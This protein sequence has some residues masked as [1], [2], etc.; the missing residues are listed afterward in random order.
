M[1][2]TLRHRVRPDIVLRNDN[3]IIA[4]E[5]TCSFETNTEKLRELKKKTGR[6]PQKQADFSS[7]LINI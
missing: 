2:D 1:D 3:Q 7:T 4:I 5:L 6:K